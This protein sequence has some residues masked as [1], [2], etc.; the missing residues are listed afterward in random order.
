MSLMTA[1][2]AR[3]ASTGLKGVGSDPS[4][5]PTFPASLVAHVAQTSPAPL[6]A[7]SSNSSSVSYDPFSSSNHNPFLNKKILVLSG[8][9]DKLVPYNFT[10]P[11]IERLEVGEDGCKEVWVQEDAGHE[12]TA[13]MRERI[14]EF[15]WRWGFE[16]SAGQEQGV[17]GDMESTK[18]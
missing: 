16:R 18:L 9:Q 12:C 17:K 14:A 10:A 11:F 5:P 13:E 15:V 7:S 1:R 6:P 2:A 4:G 3:F 8:A